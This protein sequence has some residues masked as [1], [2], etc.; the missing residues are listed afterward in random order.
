M[1]DL[2]SGTVP[3][4]SQTLGG[5]EPGFAGGASAL[6]WA[7]LFSLGAGSSPPFLFLQCPPRPQGR[8]LSL[9]GSGCLCW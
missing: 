7:G 9:T 3:L 5:G 2:L 6:E 8:C 4:A 1:F